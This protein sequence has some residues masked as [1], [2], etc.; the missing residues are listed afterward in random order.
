[1]AAGRNMPA[2]KVKEYADGR[3]YTGS[4]ALERKLVD[5]L[6]DSDDAVALAA[7]MGGIAGKPRIRH[8]A[9]HFSDIFEMFDSRFHGVLEGHAA[10]WDALKPSDHMGLEYR[11]TGW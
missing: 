2:E 8:E 9:D 7:R 6:G 10:L 4:Q 3:I 1:V 11:W 5:Q